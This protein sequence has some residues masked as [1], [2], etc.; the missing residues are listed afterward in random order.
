[1]HQAYLTDFGLA[2]A[3]GDS[4]VLSGTS[5]AGTVEYM[6]PEQWRGERVGPA[7]DV[8]SLGCVLY[9]A[10][11]GIVPHARQETDSEPEMPGGL[12]TVIDRAVSKDPADRY[13]SAGA[14]I[15]AAR[16]HEGATPAATR[17]LSDSPGRSTAVIRGTRRRTSAFDYR[18][19]RT[20]L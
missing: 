14:L 20:W 2:K 18:G 6:S 11:T 1:G 7:A 3:L 13:P 15:A 5:I 8:Y 4:G 12:D 17:V 9:E 16:E 10:V 19:R